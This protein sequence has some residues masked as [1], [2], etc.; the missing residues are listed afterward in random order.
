MAK[1][2]L[3]SKPPI[4]HKGRLKTIYRHSSDAEVGIVPATFVIAYSVMIR[5]IHTANVSNHPVDHHHL[6]VVAVIDIASERR[7]HHF[8]ELPELNPRICHSAEE[9]SSSPKTTDVVA[10]HTYLHPLLCLLD[11]SIGNSFAR[12]IIEKDVVL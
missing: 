8:E 3:T 4:T 6:A 7:H 9:S 2:Y 11:Q 10:H 12:I 1:C 5:D